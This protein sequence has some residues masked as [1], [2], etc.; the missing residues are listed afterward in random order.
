MQKKSES[1]F[2]DYLKD[3]P[4]EKLL[5]FYEEI[6]W[7]PFPLL[8]LREYQR[9]FKVKSKDVKDKVEAEKILAKER[10]LI[11]KDFAEKGYQL[12]K[13]LTSRT[14]KSISSGYNTARRLASTSERDVAVLEKLGDLRK[15]GV[16]TQKE[17]E[18]KK[19]DILERI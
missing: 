19:K 4:N 6:E 14:S 17:F 16:I 8:I 18:E 3:I 13:D 9:R 12:S 15:K 1:R 5:Q 11:L 2:K 10:R 7:T